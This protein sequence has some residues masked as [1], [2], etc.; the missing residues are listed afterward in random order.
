MLRREIRGRTASC[1]S[2]RRTL[3]RICDS[4]PVRPGTASH[5]IDSSR[6]C[7]RRMTGMASPRMPS[8][9]LDT[10]LCHDHYILR[11]ED[12]SELLAISAD[13]AQSVPVPEMPLLRECETVSLLSERINMAFEPSL[14]GRAA[15]LSRVTRTFIHCAPGFE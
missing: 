1:L 9:S 5:C 8:D 2:V 14:Q 4:H 11:V 7:T 6:A 12:S 15:H 13:S 10:E 3:R